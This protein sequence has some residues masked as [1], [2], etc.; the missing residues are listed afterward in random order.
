M[1]KQWI[2]IDRDWILGLSPRAVNAYMVLADRSWGWSGDMPIEF[3]KAL[4]AARAA[5]GQFHDGKRGRDA[6][7]KAALVER[8]LVSCPDGRTIIP[9]VVEAARKASGKRHQTANKLPLNCQQTATPPLQV[10]DSKGPDSGTGDVL[11]L[12]ER[13]RVSKTPLRRLP[14]DRFKRAM[15]L[16]GELPE[17]HQK[18]VRD[19]YRELRSKHG[20]GATYAH[21]Y[22]EWERQNI[23]VV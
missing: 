16:Y 13:I 20:Q 21:A 4:Q 12:R 8:G 9:K 23:P 14:T 15:R 22:F 18:A 2:K 17:V 19:I 3:H 10:V 7:V 1:A 11:R 5:V 6:T